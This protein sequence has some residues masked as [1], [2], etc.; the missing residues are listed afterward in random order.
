MTATQSDL[1][2]LS[3]FIFRAPRWYTSLGFALLIAAMAGIAA[4][5]SGTATESWR[6][7]FIVGQ[8]AWEG[9]FYIG[10]PTVI[11]SVGTAGVDR[12]LGG[13]LTPNR[14]SLLALVCELILVVALTAAA[15]VT[16]VTPLGQTF[17]FDVLVI[18]LS[19][20]FAFR[21][22]VVM[23]VSRS[24]IL[25]AAVPASIQTVASAVLLFVYSGTVR[26]L[27]VGGPLLQA[28]MMPYLARADR[29][30]PELLIVG[31]NH[32]AL[33]VVTSFIY[34][35]AVYVFIRVIDR[36]WERSLGVSM[37]DFLRGFIGHIEGSRE[38]EDFFEQLGQEAIVPVTVLSFRRLDG[39]EK[40]R[41]ILP[42]I[43]PGPMGEIGGGNFPERVAARA[44][45]LAFPPHATAGHDFNLVT[46][47][48]VDTILDAVDRAYEKITYSL[49]A[50][51]SV[52]VQS[53][54]AKMLGQAFDDSALLVSTYAPGFADDV[55]YA[56]G[57][58]AATEARTAGHKNVLLVD[59]HNS[60]NGLDGP[61]LGHVTPGSKRS[62]DMIEAAGDVGRRLATAP[63]GELLLGTAWDDTP[64]G[65]VDGIG[66]LGIRV[67]VTEVDGQTTAYV[68]VDGNNMEPGLRDRI[69][70]ALD[71]RIDV[72]EVMTTDTHIVNTVEADNQVGAVLDHD[73]LVELVSDLVDEALADCEPV[74]AGMAT[75]RAEVTVFGNDRTETLASHANAVVS[76]GG[77][78]A[79]AV[80][81]AAMAVS[82]LIFFLT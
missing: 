49:E 41:W 42:M 32:F 57:L 23:A 35:T 6:R 29:A 38:L 48:E 46:E 8:D 54:E 63:R 45:G 14:S 43:H 19:S 25:V 22:L 64:W 82:V 1:A 28:Y 79:G 39:S 75:E 33:L 74:S 5:D 73:E 4:F 59:A 37:L 68:L 40:A 67:T 44:E 27:E 12:F 18:A 3:R 61:D 20:I 26:F 13:K 69:I 51:Q 11:A 77:A 2:G 17:V 81:L 36:P 24:S 55:E 62:F 78:L 66:P 65:P 21:L 71:D 31:P 72:S 80:I 70:D 76:L 52:R 53:G 60:N 10:I 30:P 7:V 58:S 47:R 15:V 9:V 34:A 56:V 50:T 16:V